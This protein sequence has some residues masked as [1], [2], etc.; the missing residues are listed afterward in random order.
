MLGKC[1]NDHRKRGPD[2]QK[3][4]KGYTVPRSYCFTVRGRKRKK[5]R[6]NSKPELYF[7]IQLG[8]AKR[9]CQNEIDPSP[10][11]DLGQPERHAISSSSPLVL[12]LARA[13]GKKKMR[14]ARGKPVAAEASRCEGKVP[15][16]RSS[17]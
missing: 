7:Q 16:N 17:S 9:A 14:D 12:A 10:E 6:W 2:R 3:K 4:K 13:K 1:R 5:F 15:L 8:T 11:R